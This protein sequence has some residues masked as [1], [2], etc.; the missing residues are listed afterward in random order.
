[1]RAWF[2]S[3]GS[4][5]TEPSADWCISAEACAQSLPDIA[6]DDKLFPRLGNCTTKHQMCTPAQRNAAAAFIVEVGAMLARRGLTAGRPHGPFTFAEVTETLWDAV[7]DLL[8]LVGQPHARHESKKR[9][10]VQKPMDEAA[11]SRAGTAVLEAI[12]VGKELA[13]VYMAPLCMDAVVDHID[14]AC[15]DAFGHTA[16]TDILRAHVVAACCTYEPSLFLAKTIIRSRIADEVFGCT[17]A[18]NLRRTCFFKDWDL[19]PD[20]YGC[21]AALARDAAISELLAKQSQLVRVK[22]A[23]A[24]GNMGEVRAISGMPMFGFE[25]DRADRASK[26]YRNSE[27]ESHRK[28]QFAAA[29][30]LLEF[31]ACFKMLPNTLGSAARLHAKDPTVLGLRNIMDKLCSDSALRRFVPILD[32]AVEEVV[33]DELAEALPCTKRKARY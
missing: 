1:M 9:R 27:R 12:F 3:L 14:E 8:P 29:E 2:A 24:T 33:K 15:V 26:L 25:P 10:R 11:F 4:A 21:S 23:V 32:I 22:Q 20:G 31:N 30:T 16:D 19:A 6:G 13:A 17:L 18:T 5:P 28:M 7:A